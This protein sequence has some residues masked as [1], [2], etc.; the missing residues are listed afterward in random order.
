MGK[1]VNLNP[2]P[3]GNLSLFKLQSVKVCYAGFL[4]DSC[5]GEN[6][7]GSGVGRKSKADFLSVKTG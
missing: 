1:P 6:G 7:C 2:I 5:P 4:A 3:I